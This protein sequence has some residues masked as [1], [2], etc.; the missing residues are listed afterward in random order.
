[1]AAWAVIADEDVKGRD[2]GIR[3]EVVAVIVLA[4][5]NDLVGAKERK[6]CSMRFV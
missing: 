1:M 2:V 6:D 5:K 3:D 4:F